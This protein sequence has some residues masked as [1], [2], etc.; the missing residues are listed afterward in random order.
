M[1]PIM[2]QLGRRAAAYIVTLF[3]KGQK[4]SARKYKV[5]DGSSD[6]NNIVSSG[7]AVQANTVKCTL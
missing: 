3:R 5:M 7:K 4:V 2:E 6:G 1:A